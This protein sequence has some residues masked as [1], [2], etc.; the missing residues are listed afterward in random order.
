M[1]RIVL[2][3]VVLLSIF[4]IYLVYASPV[5]LPN[6]INGKEG[7]FITESSFEGEY[8]QEVGVSTSFVFDD[9][10]RKMKDF[11]EKAKANIFA[12]K[13]DIS[14]YNRFDIYT[15]LGGISNANYDLFYQ[16][17]TCI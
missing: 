13:L 11:D 9:L 7:L 3:A 15:V 5:Y 16:H 2:W 10:K 14:F 12:G 6:G 1:K 17:E 4:S 8:P